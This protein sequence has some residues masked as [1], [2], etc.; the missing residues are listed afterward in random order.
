MIKAVLS[1]AMSLWKPEREIV[2]GSNIIIYKFQVFLDVLI[3][4]LTRIPA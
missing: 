2:E 1:A 3:A 4:P